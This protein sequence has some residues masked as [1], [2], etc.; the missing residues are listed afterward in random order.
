MKDYEDR[1]YL[2]VTEVASYLG[3]TVKKVHY[4]VRSKELKSYKSAGGQYRF[5][6]AGV[7]NIEIQL[8]YKGK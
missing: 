2:S 7:E 3:L 5:D 8:L 4:L 1:S 6:I